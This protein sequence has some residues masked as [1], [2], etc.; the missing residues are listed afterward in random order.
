[1]KGKDI[2]ILWTL[3]VYL[4]VTAIAITLSFSRFEIVS[5]AFIAI[6]LLFSIL[7]SWRVTKQTSLMFY[8]HSSFKMEF[9]TILLAF[10]LIF[11][12]R[13][14]IY[15]LTYGVWEK[16][17]MIVLSFMLITFVDRT[18][19]IDYGLA[20]RYLG[21]QLVW[22]IGSITG[23]WL[24]FAFVSVIL[25]IVLGLSVTSYTLNT[26]PINLSILLPLGM[27][28]LGNF[29]EEIFFRGYIQTKLKRFGLSKAILIQAAFFGLYHLNYMLTTNGSTLSFIGYIF[30]TFLFGIFVGLLFEL[31]GSVIV[32]TF[33]HAG[34]NF[35][36]SYLRFSPVAILSNGSV[37]YSSYTYGVTLIILI[38]I[39]GFLVKHRNNQRV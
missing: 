11:L 32:T 16:A 37:F 27:F 38:V 9:I 33:V 36:F 12:T 21:R 26:I 2:R 31:T 8:V 5:I 3:G 1:M 6:V 29:A 28:L 39:T 35:F 22:S 7:F 18:K 19:L 17:G 15:W 20:L 30:F 34:M 23:V 14:G 4:L 13:F 25:P 10:S 24:I